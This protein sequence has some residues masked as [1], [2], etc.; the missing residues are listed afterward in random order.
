MILIRYERLSNGR[1]LLTPFIIFSLK[2]AC[3][4]LLSWAKWPILFLKIDY[5]DNKGGISTQ[6]A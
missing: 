4:Y 3:Y 5:L 6:K 1:Y 2:S